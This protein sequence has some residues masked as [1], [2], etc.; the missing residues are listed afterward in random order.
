[1]TLVV[2]LVLKGQGSVASGPALPS[3]KPQ[4]AGGPVVV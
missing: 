2:N 1:M 3:G 4:L